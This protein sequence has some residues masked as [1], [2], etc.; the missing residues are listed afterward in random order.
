[1]AAG[2]G[3]PSLVAAQNAASVLCTDYLKEAVD[4]IDIS[5]AK[6][7][8]NNVQTAVLN[9]HNVPANLNPEVLLLSDINYEPSEFPVL[10]EVIIRF[11]AKG[12][13]ILLSTPQRLMA[14]SFIADILQWCW[15]QEV[16]NVSTNEQETMISIYVLKKTTKV[17]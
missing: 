2:L 9:W 3:L 16:I 14:K 5:I 7:G 8:F 15:R 17:D 12:T 13:T 6:N 4:I 10:K 11:I 1:L